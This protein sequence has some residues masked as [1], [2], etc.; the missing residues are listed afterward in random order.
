MSEALTFERAW[1]EALEAWAI[2]QPILDA[3]PDSPYGF[4]AELFAR[5]GHRSMHGRDAPTPTTSRALKALGRNELAGGF[6]FPGRI[7]VHDRPS[8]MRVAGF[9]LTGLSFDLDKLGFFFEWGL[10]YAQQ[11][12]EA[13]ERYRI[14]SIPISIHVPIFSWFW[15]GASFEPNLLFTK[16]IFDDDEGD[17]GFWSPVR[18]WQGVQ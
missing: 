12:T 13:N 11:S 7:S 9:S 17:P 5:R 16:T 10:S 18:A 15:F 3:V 4:P 6:W 8:S 14:F 2:P 1:A